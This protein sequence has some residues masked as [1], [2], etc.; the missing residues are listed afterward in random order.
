MLEVNIRILSLICICRLQLIRQCICSSFV[1]VQQN[2]D[3]VQTIRSSATQH[4]DKYA[5]NMQRC[6]LCYSPC[7][8]M[9][10]T[11]LMWFTF[12]DI[13]PFVMF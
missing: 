4:F 5:T 9:M 2:K 7:F 12:Q 1:A 6:I 8:W 11:S 3:H 10:L 13:Q